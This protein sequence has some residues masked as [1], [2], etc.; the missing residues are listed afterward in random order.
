MSGPGRANRAN[1]E[2][3]AAGYAVAR[4]AFDGVFQ[5]L[6]YNLRCMYHLTQP[7]VLEYVGT[8]L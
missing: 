3:Y 5:R 2:L 4:M 1:L 8:C 7:Q 6:L